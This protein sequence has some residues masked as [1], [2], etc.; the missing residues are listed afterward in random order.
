MVSFVETNIWINTYGHHCQRVKEGRYGQCG[1][2]HCE[3]ILLAGEHDEH[4]L[5]YNDTPE[6]EVNQGGWVPRPDE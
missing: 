1:G 5:Q 4:P 2:H 3:G 6:V